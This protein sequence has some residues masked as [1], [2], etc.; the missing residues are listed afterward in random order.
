[1]TAW[2]DGLFLARSCVIMDNSSTHYNL[3][4]HRLLHDAGIRVR[5]FVVCAM[6]SVNT[7][8]RVCVRS[9]FCQATA[10]NSTPSNLPSP[11]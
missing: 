5:Y 11:K 4:F 10:R 8:M 2:V 6:L 7:L 3:Q 1:M 9:F